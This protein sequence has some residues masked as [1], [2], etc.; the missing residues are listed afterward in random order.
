MALVIDSKNHVELDGIPFRLAEGAEGQHHNVVGEPLRPPNAVTVQGESQQKFQ[1]RPEVLLWNWTDW[2]EGEGRRTLRFGDAGRSWQL[3]AVRVFEEPGHLIPGYYTEITQDST[4]ASDLAKSLALVVGMGNL[5][6]LDTNADD[7]Y[8]WDG[9]KWGAAAT[10]SGPGVGSED[11]AVGDSDAIYWVERSTNNVFK[12]TGS[13]AATKISDVTI[14]DDDVYIDHLGPYV[15]VYSP[16]EAS[17]WEIPKDGGSDGTLIDDFEETG[18][19]PYGRSGITTLHG[20]AYV[21]VSHTNR[22]M[23]RE[24]TPTTAAGT[25]YGAEI[26]RI[27]GFTGEAI[28]SHSGSLFMLGRYRDE[29]GIDRTVLY[30]TPGGEYGTLGEIRSG[31]ALNGGTGGSGRMLDHFFVMTRQDATDANHTLFQIDSVSGGIAALSY[32]AVGDAT[33]EQP[34][35]VTCFEGDIFWSTEHTATAKRTMRAYPGA[36]QI[37]S[38]AISSE[39][40]FDLVSE[41]FLSSMVLSCEPLPADWTVYV[42]YQINGSGTWVNVITYTTDGGTGETVAVT[43]DSSTVEFK[44]LQMRC[45]FSY[46]GGGIPTS[47]PVVLGIEARAIVATK[48][49]V[50]RLLLDLST[51]QSAG[52]QSKE[53]PAKIDQFQA[54]VAK[55]TSVDFKDGYTSHRSGEYDNYDVFVDDYAIILNTPGEGVAAVTLRE[56]I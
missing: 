16:I 44:R 28:W 35:S 10:I 1:P 39:H 50:V 41:K 33:G 36:Y 49:R 19:V 54:I 48:V 53:G 34:R 2:S 29:A 13:G 22:T 23:V 56:V 51:D 5:Y 55:S 43:T 11:N 3:R 18:D 38:Q 7:V 27:D 40:D 31:V 21:M 32:D 6:G 9:A 20:R 8:L 52:K 46:T 45:R 12:W 42:D 24:I 30:L 37:D 47:A 15:Y 14:L 4:G 25:G 26:A 17:V